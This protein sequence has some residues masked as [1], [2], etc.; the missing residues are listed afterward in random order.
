MKVLLDEN[1]PHDLRHFLHMHQAFTVAYM[2]WKGLE[3][4]DLLAR[5]A[6]DG[7]DVLL[8]KDTNL[9]YQQ[10]LTELPIA[11]VVLRAASNAIDDIRPLVPDLLRAS[12]ALDPR[13]VT[14]VG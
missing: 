14:V 12:S 10:N 1:L 9:H 6:E 8:T 3:N 4:G 11:V 13:T 7:F 5:A 2:R